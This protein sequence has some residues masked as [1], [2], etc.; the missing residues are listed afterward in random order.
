[1]RPTVKSVVVLI[2]CLLLFPGQ[3][4]A[5]AKFWIQ[6]DS[7]AVGYDPSTL[8]VVWGGLGRPE[9]PDLRGPDQPRPGGQRGLG[10]RTTQQSQVVAARAKGLRTLELEGSRLLAHVL[11]AEPGEFT[12]PVIPET[13]SAKGWILP[14]FEGV[15]APCGDA[16]W[17]SFLTNRG[18][19]NTTA[20]LT[21]P[22]LG[23]DYGRA[24]LT[25][26]LTNP[27]NNQLEFRRAPDKALQARLTH[28]FT[29]NHPVKEY[30]VVFEVGNELTGRARPAIPA[31]AHPAG[32]VRQPQGQDPQDA[33]GREAAGRRARLSLGPRTADPGRCDR[34]EEA[35]P[36][37]QSPGRG[38]P[39][40]RPASGFGP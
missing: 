17:A 22:F 28:Q 29:R 36:G 30:G 2:S 8:E 24:T 13:A 4:R 19:L 12:F 38:A 23:L 5:G 9:I 37:A 1:M 11:A 35:C 3:L 40:R 27:F 32:R 34:L 26:I 16:R 6:N 14:F 7:C 20:D 18:E 21:M 25:C 31:V 15:Y 39:R 10:R 33:R